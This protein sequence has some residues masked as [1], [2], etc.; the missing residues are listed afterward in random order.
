MATTTTN[1]PQT[2][3]PVVGKLYSPPNSR[4]TSDESTDGG[5]KPKDNDNFNNNFNNNMEIKK[6]Y[7][8]IRSALLPPT[9]TQKYDQRYLYSIPQVPSTQQ[10]QQQQPRQPQMTGGP[11]VAAGQGKMPFDGRQPSQPN[12]MADQE[13]LAR[14]NEVLETSSHLYY[15]SKDA[16]DHI[17]EQRPN[18]EVLHSLVRRAR[19][20]SEFLE[21]WYHRLVQDEQ[22]RGYASN[23]AVSSMGNG[24]NLNAAKHTGGIGYDLA[25]RDSLKDEDGSRKP[26][27]R[28]RQGS[29]ELIRCHQCGTHETPEWRKGPEGSRTLCNACG[30]FHAKLVKKKGEAEAAEILRGRREQNQTRMSVDRS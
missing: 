9:P 18:L 19:G 11:S 23:P 29:R 20:S 15:F 24:S 17:T 5:N 10:P 28:G 25:R 8:P 13:L 3:P 16:V 1:S 30:L 22:L 12:I 21:F 14:L 2:S 27:K 7:S 4:R 6:D 26:K